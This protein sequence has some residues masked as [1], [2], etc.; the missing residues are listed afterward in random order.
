[1]YFLFFS[2]HREKSIEKDVPQILNIEPNLMFFTLVGSALSILIATVMLLSYY[3]ERD[4]EEFPS[5]SG[6]SSQSLSEETQRLLEDYEK[7]YE[8]AF[9]V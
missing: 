5:I 4:S 6:E 8:N 3:F 7:S 9:S 2:F 1:M